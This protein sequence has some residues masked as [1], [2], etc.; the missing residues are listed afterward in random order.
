MHLKKIETLQTLCQEMASLTPQTDNLVGARHRCES[1]IRCL[2]ED[3]ALRT[4][5]KP[6][7][8]K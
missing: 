4:P 5:A 1:A 6:E 2:I 7:L 8:K 3:D